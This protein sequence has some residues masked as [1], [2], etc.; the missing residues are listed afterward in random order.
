[1]GAWPTRNAKDTQFEFAYYLS[2]ENLRST[3][4]KETPTCH[5]CPVA[6]KREVEVYDGKLKHKSE[7]PEFESIWALRA[8]IG[9][10]HI[11][12]VSYLNYLANLYGLHNRARQHTGRRSRSERKRTSQRRCEMGR[13]RPLR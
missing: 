10:G 13:R 1:M 11:E 8:M 2:G 9:L 6:C 3:I 4:L 5:P 12:A 7:G